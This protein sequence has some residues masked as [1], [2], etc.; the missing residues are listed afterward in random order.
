LLPLY[1]TEQGFNPGAA[2]MIVA[3][4]PLGAAFSLVVSGWLYDRLPPRQRVA[5]FGG[6]LLVAAGS[7]SVLRRPAGGASSPWLLAASLFTTMA[8]VA[9]ALYLPNSALILNHCGRY[10]G[11]VMCVPARPC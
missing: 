9:P 3:S 7:L 2:A 11:T 6:L 4:Y 8:G 5:Y 10:S 1:L